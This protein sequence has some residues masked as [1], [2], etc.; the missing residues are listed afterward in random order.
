MGEA[1]FT[2]AMQTEVLAPVVVK[3]ITGSHLNEDF[4]GIAQPLDAVGRETVKALG[5]LH[6]RDLVGSLAHNVGNVGHIGLFNQVSGASG[7]VGMNLRNLGMGST[8]TLINGRRSAFTDYDQHGEGYVDLAGLMPSIAIDRVEIM[9]GGASAIY[10]SSADAGVVNFI[11]RRGVEGI[12]ARLDYGEDDDTGKQ[13]DTL[14]EA[15]AGLQTEHLDLQLAVSYLRREP[16]SI[17]DRYAE[18]GRSLISTSSQLGSR[19]PLAP[20][21]ADPDSFFHSRPSGQFGEDH[22]LDCI[23]AASLDGPWRGLGVI[24]TADGSRCTY[25]LSGFYDLVAKESNTKIHFAGYYH[26]AENL[27][28]D[29]E[30]TYTDN[31]FESSSAPLPYPTPIRLEADHPGLILDANRRGILPVPY[32]ITNQFPGG[33]S[34]GTPKADTHIR[35]NFIRAS[36]GMNTE[37]AI[38]AQPWSMDLRLTWS[39]RQFSARDLA[40]SIASRVQ[41]A[42]EGFGGVGCARDSGTPGSGNLGQGECYYYNPFATAYL[43]P[44]TGAPW[45]LSDTLD[46]EVDPS[47][48]VQEAAALYGNSADLLDWLAAVRRQEIEDRQILLDFKVAGGLFGAAQIALGM[49]WRQDQIKVDWD[50]LYNA[51]D[52]SLA[53]GAQDFSGKEN[54]SSA[55]VEFS[56]PILARLKVV[57]T[58]RYERFNLTKHS[59][60]NPMISLIYRPVDSLILRATAA[61]SFQNPTITQVQGSWTSLVRSNDPF[62]EFNGAEFRPVLISGNPDLEPEKGRIYGAGLTLTP[63]LETAFGGLRLRL[64]VFHHA[65]ENAIFRTNYQNLIARDVALRCPDGVNREPSL[66]R[67]CGVLGGVPHG[68]A[69]GLS[70]QVVRDQYGNL[71]H[72]G[73]S[74]AN[75]QELNVSGLELDVRQQ[76]GF[77]RLH[78]IAVHLAFM[79]MLQYEL[80]DALGQKYDGLGKRNYRNDLGRPVPQGK[81]HLALHWSIGPNLLIATWNYVG[82]YR[83]DAPRDPVSA[84]YVDA[85]AKIKAYTSLDLQYSLKLPAFSPLRDSPVITFGVR[86]IADAEPSAVRLDGAYDPSLHDPRGRTWYGGFLLRI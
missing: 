77:G 16:L 33:G 57:A 44:N 72:V 67:L 75:A 43:D 85:G 18:F 29:V 32:L 64:D 3:P 37:I 10:G 42:A 17:G 30:F 24:R 8:L 50:D 28:F 84:N 35:R 80:V 13:S 26:P 68:L 61:T 38:A 1:E 14:F 78:R 12:E 56:W 15:L 83:D 52:Y 58:G 86:N 76:F 66:G 79:R 53:Y 2:E 36:A 7:Q 20:L 65:Y 21:Q 48:S 19:I 41:A 23:L 70:D 63:P 34:A 39:E 81:G 4:L 46:W 22:D 60:L 6:V 49:Q 82:G 74:Y 59:S 27:E 25:D 45:D 47:L 71:M 5:A 69:E 73:L 11:T 62:A 51:N 55:Y 40:D 54:I 9:R 31:D